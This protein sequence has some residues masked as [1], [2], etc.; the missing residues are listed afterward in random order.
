M[1][2]VSPEAELALLLA[3]TSTT[4]QRLRA[5]ITEL[6][7]LIDEDAFVAFLRRQRMVLLGGSRLAEIAP[8][9]P[10][11]R[12]HRRLAEARAN[13]RAGA[14]LFAT[15]SRHLTD[16]LE[17]DAIQAVE[18]KGARLA[19]DLHGDGALRAYAD[20]D[21]LVPTDKLDEAAAAACRLGWREPTAAAPDPRPTLHRSLDHPDGALP[22]LELHW[23]VHWYETRFAEAMLSRSRVVDGARRLEPVDQLAALLLFYA[24]DG[25]NGL[26]LAADVGAWWDRYGDAETLRDL[27]RLVVEH[28]ELAEA[29]RTALQ[30]VSPLV[31]LPTTTISTAFDPRTRRGAL[32]CRMR[33]W[34]LRGDVDQIHANVSLVDGL[35]SP[36]Q[37]LGAFLRRYVILTRLELSK[38]YGFAPDS[39]FR[40]ACW[41]AWHPV[42]MVVRYVLGLARLTGGRS[43]SALPGSVR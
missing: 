42:K 11:E 14:L 18:L 43:W 8:H 35:L 12:F 6:A 40:V 13:A 19:E 2:D 30:A 10:S 5:R 34:D 38:T 24:R 15:A 16:A 41:R 20:I 26:R 31:G 1:A 37:Q 36:R 17:R 27:G 22:V 4:R 33:N 25:F 9:A 7:E 3:A 39:R 29:W 21:I 28:P 32:A 23:R